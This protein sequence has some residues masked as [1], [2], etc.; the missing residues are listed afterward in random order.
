MAPFEWSF[1]PRSVEFTVTVR[2]IFNPALKEAS[3]VLPAL[4]GVFPS[5][6]TG[7]FESF[8]PEGRAKDG[9]DGEEVA[10]RTTLKMHPGAK[11]AVVQKS[12]GSVNVT[13]D[14]VRKLQKACLPVRVHPDGKE[15]GGAS[16][17][18]ARVH[19]GP[20]LLSRTRDEEVQAKC[21]TLKRGEPVL[22]PESERILPPGEWLAEKDH[23]ARTLQPCQ[24]IA[25][26]TE[27][28]G[29][30]GLFKLEVTISTDIP[31]LSDEMLVQLLPVCFTVDTVRNLPNDPAR[32][33][34]F[35][36]VYVEVLPITNSITAPLLVECP[37]TK[38]QGAR[39]HNTFLRFMEPV[40]YLLGLCDQHSVREWFT[41]Q[42]LTVEIHDQDSRIKPPVPEDA[43]DD[44]ASPAKRSKVVFPHGYARFDLNALLDTKSLSIPLRADVFPARGNK[45]VR[46]AEGIVDT[47]SAKGLL[48]EEGM[49]RLADRTAEGKRED[50]FDYHKLG[51]TCT[52]RATLA[53]PIPKAPEIQGVVEDEQAAAWA[54]TEQQDDQTNIWAAELEEKTGEETTKKGKKGSPAKGKKD[55]VADEAAP[56]ATWSPKPFRVKLSPAD[57]SDQ[58]I[59]PWRLKRADAEEDEQAL[60]AV[61]KPEAPAAEHGA[62][63]E[64]EVQEDAEA[65]R[66]LAT[67]LCKQPRKG[68]HLR[69]EKYGRVFF[70]LK[71]SDTSAI[72]RVLNCVR[73]HNAGTLKIDKNSKQLDQYQFSEQQLL[74]PHFDMLTGFV[75]MDG[76]TRMAVVEG[77][78]DGGL[79]KF[80]DEAMPR[81]EQPDGVQSGNGK[82]FKMLYNADIGFSERL[83]SKMGAVLKTVK[84]RPELSPVER[85]ASRSELYS[86]AGNVSAD[87]VAAMACPRL[88]LEL[89]RLTRQRNMREGGS[90]PKYENIANL[91]VL[92][93]GYITDEEIAGHPAGTGQ[94]DSSGKKSGATNARPNHAAEAEAALRGVLGETQAGPGDLDS[95]GAGQRRKQALDKTDKAEFYSGTLGTWLPARQTLEH[96]N[97]DF[98]VSL[99]LRKSESAPDF[100]RSNKD[101]VKERSTQNEQCNDL[102]GKKRQRQTP[103]LDDHEEVFMYSSQKLNSAELQKE[104]M[105]AHMDPQAKDK[106][107][108]YNAGYNNCSFEFSGAELPGVKTVDNTKPSKPSDTYARLPGDT[109]P[110]FRAEPAR[111]Q[112]TFKKPPR[113][114]SEMR[115]EDLH[116]P[117]VENE[118]HQMAV[119][120]ERRK[121]LAQ[122]VRFDPD[123]LPHRRV[124]SEQPFD[125]SRINNVG[126]D[127]GPRSM[128]ESV[129]YH[130]EG[131][132]GEERFAENARR[133]NQEWSKQDQKKIQERHTKTFTQTATRQGATCLDRRE[134]IRKDKQMKVIS[135]DKSKTFKSDEDATNR[136]PPSFRIL[137]EHHERGAP[138]R[139][140]QAR[141]RENDDSP[142]YDVA[143]G[144]YL[145]RDHEIGLKRAGFS[146][147]LGKAPWRHGSTGETMLKPD[148]TLPGHAKL[149]SST[150]Y[151][152]NLDFDRTRQP[153]K[154][155]Q[156]ESHIHKNASRTSLT[157]DEKSHR[158]YRRPADFGVR[159]PG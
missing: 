120:I 92:Y 148:G 23:A 136:Q 158:N 102:F 68:M 107:Y 71:D 40:V 153:P 154:S 35:E 105:R 126:S 142:P 76:Q 41:H 24:V 25:T 20:L 138:T 67:K 70:L 95:P 42:G 139:D 53:M 147:T 151:A 132:P 43:G 128:T 143:T 145:P 21:D 111:D 18:N 60:L 56:S 152:S 127:F 150:E 94:L 159:I 45:K 12:M 113:D 2:A 104:W 131:A 133:T 33:A 31:V 141:M 79:Q 156:T 22:D 66:A 57:G 90:F 140:F 103:F 46:R 146:G 61:L 115:S 50:T 85:L 99:K 75:L 82:P 39:P 135:K 36:D 65:A 26:W 14:T 74:D 137:E 96:K 8:E 48:S 89:K 9:D 73:E 19:L 27:T 3:V 38:S 86:F 87:T 15:T 112:E 93:G 30:A 6:S 123:K 52:L 83:Y 125:P 110:V 72:Q 1:E 117:F 58:I 134:P 144:L 64:M 44:G 17:S 81:H 34:Q 13:M 100:Q 5:I 155:K 122:H 109:R 51:A 62:D 106:M 80:L 101:L 124:I 59:G 28:I 130:G 114:V 16:V 78:R 149:M 116:E 47:L 121:P 7:P 157:T 49:K 32:N 11:R 97:P 118:W 88:L 119:G 4:D 29:V 69:H 37:R 77:L 98:E 54:E 84:L 91:E 10:R 108:T 129:H 63:V 55:V